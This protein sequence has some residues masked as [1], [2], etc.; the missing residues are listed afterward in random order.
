MEY[1]YLL[2]ETTVTH[3]SSTLIRMGQF[4][5][6]TRLGKRKIILQTLISAAIVFGAPN[7]HE[8]GRASVI[9]THFSPMFHFYTPWRRQKTF[10]FF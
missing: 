5:L 1:Y 10:G 8:Y 2:N 6:I 9:L 3:L 4:Y 7:W